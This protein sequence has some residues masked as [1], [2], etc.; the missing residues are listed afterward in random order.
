MA[1][2][3]L[4]AQ[5]LVQAREF[6]GGGG[7]DRGGGFAAAGDRYRFSA[8]RLEPAPLERQRPA[9]PRDSGAGVVKAVEDRPVDR[10]LDQG[11]RGSHPLYG[12]AARTPWTGHNISADQF[13]RF[14]AGDRTAIG[15]FDHPTFNRR[16]NIQNNFYN[17]S[18]GG[19]NNSWADGGYWG[20]RPWG[21]GWYSWSPN[22][23][24]WWGASAVGWGL[25]ALASEA[26]ISDLVNQASAQQSSTINVPDSPYQLNYGSVD[27]VGN[28]GADFS[29]GVSGSPP[30]KG[31]VN[32][33]AGLLDGQI[34]STAAKA[35]LLNAA[36]Q[37]A[38]GPDPRG[39]PLA[40]P[41]QAPALSPATS[42][43]LTMLLGLGLGA[44]A[45]TLWSRRRSL[46]G[47]LKRPAP[48]R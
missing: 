20:S 30:V 46:A 9:L 27:A 38:Y 43:A 26:L 11:Y 1:V 18:I 2:G 31:A 21:Y 45:V 6:A 19:W 37:V 3:L 36:C 29:Y 14:K 22:T 44:G 41:G 23:W 12:E 17:R 35:Q 4:A 16:I 42:H 10:S 24:S 15:G 32:C 8:P 7:L 28:S 5:P 25:T 40:A 33:Q 48:G 47:A 39:T 13:R 34:P